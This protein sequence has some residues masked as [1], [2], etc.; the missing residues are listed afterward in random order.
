MRCARFGP[1]RGRC[2]GIFK[3]PDFGYRGLVTR[4]LGIG[5][6]DRCKA[7]HFV[8]PIS[9]QVRRNFG[10]NF[11]PAFPW[12]R[13]PAFGYRASDFGNRERHDAVGV[14]GPVSEEVRRDSV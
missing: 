7:V 14:V 13:F 3:D 8:R 12:I 9:E 10:S 11:G 4:N 1:S 2:G 6:R 5:I